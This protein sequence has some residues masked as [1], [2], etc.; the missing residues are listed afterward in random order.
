MKKTYL[1]IFLSLAVPLSFG[2]AAQDGFHSGLNGSGGSGGGGSTSPGGVNQN[3]QFNNSG[4]FG[5][6]GVWNG[7]QLTI[8]NATSAGSRNFVLTSGGVEEFFVT[9]GGSVGAQGL[10]V[11]V[12]AHAGVFQLAPGGHYLFS[13]GVDYGAG[14]SRPGGAVVRS[15][16]GSS[17]YS[18]HQ[19]QDFK[20]VPNGTSQPAC[21]VGVR[22]TI[23]YTSSAN[24]VA[25]KME[26]CAK[27]AADTYAWRV[28]A[29]IP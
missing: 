26:V 13:D 9:P 17:G 20:L 15:D 28:M 11:A 5:G 25:D 18:E 12:N 10:D 2:V 22:G 23:W 6:F 4:A 24:G 7:S 8:D 16:D 14:L 19:A 21:A 3:V 29:T 27:A 1:T